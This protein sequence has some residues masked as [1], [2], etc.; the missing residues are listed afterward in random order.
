M[1]RFDHARELVTHSEEQLD[2]IRNL[3]QKCLDEQV[4]TPTFLIEIKNFME[5]LRSALDYCAVALF[6]K[7]GHS[8]KAAPKVYFPYAKLT[9]DKSKFHSVIVERSIPGLLTSRPDIVDKLASYQHFG[10]TGNWLPQFMEITNENKH[11]QLTP[12][13]QKQA[14]A[15]LISATIPPGG[16]LDID[17]S[18]IPLGGSPDKPFQAV[19]GVWTRLEFTTHGG[20]VLLLLEFA[21][22]NVGNLVK[23]LASL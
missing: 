11:T 23:E 7:Y 2:A 22:R 3:H 16:T 10:N 19:A 18:D 12:Q 20:P 9:D 4:V 5:N 21:L 15:V 1:S 14:Q 6:D 8:T 13:V 17:L